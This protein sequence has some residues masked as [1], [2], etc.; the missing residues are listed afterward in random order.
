MDNLQIG[1]VG[2]RSE[3]PSRQA[4]ARHDRNLRRLEFRKELIVDA[5]A[6]GGGGNP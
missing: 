2:M 6:D 1:H 4:A 3:K 5:W